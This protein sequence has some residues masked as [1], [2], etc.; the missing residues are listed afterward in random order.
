M[1]TSKTESFETRQLEIAG[2]AKLLSNPARVAI[3][4][5]LMRAPKCICNDIVDEVQL[6]QPTISLHLKD[7]KQAGLI[8]GTIE[9][10]QICYCIDEDKWLQVQEMLSEWLHQYQ[11]Q[12]QKCC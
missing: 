9:G 2:I 6:A 5:Y 12:K 8:K 4:E 3:L 1:G 10:R 7:L 11:K